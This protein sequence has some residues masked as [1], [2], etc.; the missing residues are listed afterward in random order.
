[1]N[2]QA[3]KKKSY[4][5]PEDNKK[6]HKFEQKRNKMETND[7]LRKEQIERNY[8]KRQKRNR[9]VGIYAKA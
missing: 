4:Y 5:T 2:F 6:S 8:T 3:R 9:I 7:R 1:M